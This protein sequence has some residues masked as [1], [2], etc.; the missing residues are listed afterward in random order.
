VELTR[1]R[2]GDFDLDAS[3]EAGVTTRAAR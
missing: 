1:A 3:R 2:H